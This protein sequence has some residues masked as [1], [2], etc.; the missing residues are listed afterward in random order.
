[1]PPWMLGGSTESS[2]CAGGAAVKERGIVIQGQASQQKLRGIAGKGRIPK[3]KL[4]IFHSLCVLFHT[5]LKTLPPYMCVDTC[6]HFMLPVICL[7]VPKTV[8]V[9]SSREHSQCYWV[10]CRNWRCK[11]NHSSVRETCRS[12]SSHMPM[13]TSRGCGRTLEDS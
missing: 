11:V 3:G 1:M 6:K 10:M 4:I 7:L 5:P 12:A 2:G 8:T 13:G 9:P